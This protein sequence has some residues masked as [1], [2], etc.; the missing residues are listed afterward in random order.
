MA[1]MAPPCSFSVP[2]APE[3]DEA[4]CSA[5]EGEEAT[6]L[7]ICKLERELAKARARLAFF[8]AQARKEELQR[9]AELRQVTVPPLLDAEDDTN[10]G[11]ESASSAASAPKQPSPT[12]PVPV[13]SVGGGL[14]KKRRL[15]A[16]AATSRP[17]PIA[18]AQGVKSEHAAGQVGASDSAFSG[19][20]QRVRVPADVCKG[21]FQGAR[22]VVG[23][24]HNYANHKCTYLPSREPYRA[25]ALD[26]RAEARKQWSKEQCAE[27]DALMGQAAAVGE[28]VDAGDRRPEVPEVASPDEVNNGE[29]TEPASPNRQS[30]Q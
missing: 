12:S 20:R 15:M 4:E 2:A 10:E 9:L 21:C 27:H 29:L 28:G 30:E 1:A 18:I 3:I 16:G 23:Y 24:S 19:K 7:F 6:M 13:Q 26:I 17:P 11:A 8:R 14:A 5:A 22:Q 25:K